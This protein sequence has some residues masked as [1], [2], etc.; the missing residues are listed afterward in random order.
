[1]L[2]CAHRRIQRNPITSLSKAQKNTISKYYI[3]THMH[4]HMYTHTHTH[5]YTHTHTH[6][7]TYTH[8][9]THTYRVY[10][11]IHKHTH[12]LSLILS[13][14]SL[15]LSLTHT[16]TH[17]HTHTP[18][19]FS[20]HIAFYHTQLSVEE[21]SSNFRSNSRNAE[22]QSRRNTITKI[23]DIYPVTSWNMTTPITESEKEASE[24]IYRFFSA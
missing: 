9:H 15:S 1:M 10:I 14:L 7:H 18:F 22:T 8:I 5:T 12:S 20:C 23:V 2:V 6:T 13:S 3:Q 19:S 11:S 24:A 21:C 4:A 17:T 16:H